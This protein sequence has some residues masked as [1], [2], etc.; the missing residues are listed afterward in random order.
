MQVRRPSA[1]LVFSALLLATPILGCG[2][3]KP[4]AV[5]VTG[6][7]TLDGN[8]VEK[9]AVML[10]PVDSKTG[11]QPASGVT[12]G[13]GNFTLKTEKVGPGALPGAYQVTVIKKETT[14]ILPGQNGVEG[15][16]APGGIKEK[17]IIP[18]KYSMPNESGL[19][20]EVKSGMEPLKLDLRSK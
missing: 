15:G 12:D 3:G 6:V 14:G 18:K 9:A 1:F 10:M 2:S 11:G 19:K 8:P 20:V 5:P 7:V 16:I 13:Q 4:N 17:W